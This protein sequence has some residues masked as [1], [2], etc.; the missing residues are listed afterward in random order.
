MFSQFGLKKTTTDDIAKRAHISKAT[1]YRY[2]R[3][4]QEI[5]DDVVAYE[6]EQLQSAITDA[7]DAERTAFS[8][9]R[10]Y[11]LSKMGKL[12]DL[13]NLLQITREV[14]SDYWPNGTEVQDQILNRQKAIVADILEFGNRSGELDVKD[15]KLTAHLMVVSLQSVEYR[16]IFDT[17]KIPLTIYVDHM[18]DLIINGIRKR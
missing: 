5:F 16:W 13:V 1:I 4:K 17:L 6:V 15:V 9:L 3:N 8:K 14:W 11:L 12:R 7:V 2:Y 10:G 18:L